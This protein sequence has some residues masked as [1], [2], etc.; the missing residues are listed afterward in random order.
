MY[1][2]HRLLLI[3]RNVHT[4]RKTKYRFFGFNWNF[5]GVG[6]YLKFSGCTRITPGKFRVNEI[7]CYILAGLVA[8]GLVPAVRVFLFFDILSLT[9]KICLCQSVSS[10]KCQTK[11][12]S[13]G[14][15]HFGIHFFKT[16]CKKCKQEWRKG[17]LKIK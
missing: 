1:N 2:Q 17:R 10:D 14:D 16:K 3:R 6:F 7:F 8:L 5:P 9:K 12:L 4:L 15:K 13:A 11:Y